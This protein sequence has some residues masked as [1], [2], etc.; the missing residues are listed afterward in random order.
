MTLTAEE[1]ARAQAWKQRWG[2]M[3][4]TREP[5]ADRTQRRFFADRVPLIELANRRAY[6][7]LQFLRFRRARA[8]ARR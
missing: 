8:E 5:A 3:A 7:H 1:Q 6:D 4:E 2:V